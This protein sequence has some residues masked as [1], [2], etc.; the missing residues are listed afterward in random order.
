[1]QVVL[2]IKDG[3]ATDAWKLDKYKKVDADIMREKCPVVTANYTQCLNNKTW[4]VVFD[5]PAIVGMCGGH[6][7]HAMNIHHTD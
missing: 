5:G 6:K 3:Q 2:D 7:N 4:I 1:M